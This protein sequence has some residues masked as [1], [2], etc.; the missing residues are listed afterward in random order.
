MFPEPKTSLS[1]RSVDEKFSLIYEE[2]RRLASSL[3]RAEMHATIRSTALVDEAWI[4]LKDSPQLAN[5]STGHFKA[6][7]ANAMRQVLVEEARRRNALKR[8]GAENVLF[9]TLGENDRK[10]VPVD[11][12][13]LDLDAA[14]HELSLMNPRQSQIVEN[15]F[16]GGMTVSETAQ[17]LEASES[18]VERDWRAAKAWL[19]TR[20]RPPKE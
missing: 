13:L 3:R 1:N 2:L 20:I 19:A 4:K 15:I 9:L 6:I 16:F 8:G 10:I 17:T 12:E 18:L 7:A 11:A 14:L 5:T